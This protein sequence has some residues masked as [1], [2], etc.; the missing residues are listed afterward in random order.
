VAYIFNKVS[1]KKFKRKVPK[2]VP[3]PPKVSQNEIG[4]EGELPPPE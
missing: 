1:P 4:S 3:P 2:P